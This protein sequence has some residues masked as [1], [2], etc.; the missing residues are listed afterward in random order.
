MRYTALIALTLLLSDSA[1]SNADDPAKISFVRDIAP[2]FV[3]HCVGCHN[4]KKK[5]GKYDMSTYDRLFKPGRRKKLIVV[6]DPDESIL[7]L[8]MHGD[9]APEMPKDADLLD[10]NIVAKVD[11]WIKQGAKFDGPDAAVP[12]AQLAAP[13]RKV[14]PDYSV[15]APVTAV[16]FSP[17][18]KTLAVAG[19]HEISFWDPQTGAYRDRWGTQS[20]RIHSLS[21]SRDGK[22]LLYAGGTPGK[23]GEV[24]VW[25]V[26]KK[27]PLRELGRYT[28]IIYGAALSPDDNRAA[29]GG[30]DRIVRIWETET[31]KKIREVDLH[32]DWIYCV[33]FTPDGKQIVT[34]SRDKT[35]K[36]LDPATGDVS[37]TFPDHTDAA[38]SAL[39]SPN[40]S[41]G[42]SV[43]ADKR[44]RFWKTDS[45]GKQTKVTGGHSDSIFTLV[46]S[47]DGK[48]LFTASA[49]RRVRTWDAAEG[50]TIRELNGHK[51]WVYALALSSDGKTLASGA[52]DGE[53]RT[54]ETAT[55]KPL[56]DFVAV[57][58]LAKKQ[59]PTVS[60]AEKSNPPPAVNSSSSEKKNDDS[61]N[62]SMSK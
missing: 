13:K 6:G 36:L 48:T 46:A 8:M 32:A 44:L 47:S 5:D 10:E 18:G 58:K 24:V 16:A 31:G 57:P 53:V 21:Y 7:A 50:K 56:I 9:E 11:L 19:Y 1:P 38:F 60:V 59:N 33:R 4:E 29:A 3:D 52:W 39:L 20:E 49:D 37:L 61:L 41:A 12:L 28:D 42:M 34:A 2:I 26:E 23:F 27:K 14:D 45:E 55:G 35:V 15:P 43:G 25:D 54:W 62:R 17:D 40:G 30:V 22:R 51:D